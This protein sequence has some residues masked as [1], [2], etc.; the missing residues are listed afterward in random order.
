[1]LLVAKHQIPL[2]GWPT[3]V[4]IWP[5]WNENEGKKNH[6]CPNKEALDT[7]DIEDKNH[8]F[9]IEQ[10]F[11]NQN[12]DALVKGSNFYDIPVEWNLCFP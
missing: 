5:K 11:G 12:Y 10:L 4:S 2:N 1:M 8:S 9:I 7:I 3:P 6:P